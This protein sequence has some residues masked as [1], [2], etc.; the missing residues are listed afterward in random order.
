MALNIADRG[1][2]VRMGQT[3]LCDTASGLLQNDLVRQTYLGSGRERA[4]RGPSGDARWP[5]SAAHAARA[6][7]RFSCGHAP[8]I[9][10]N[11]TPDRLIPG[12]L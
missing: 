10:E 11:V 9:E 8:S 2:V 4:D 6:A 3:V 12:W 7:V 5:G 1:Y